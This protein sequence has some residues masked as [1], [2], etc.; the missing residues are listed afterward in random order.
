MACRDVEKGEEAAASIRA[1]CP[2]AEVE[3]RELDLADTCSIR[4]FAQKFLRGT[5]RVS[6]WYS[7]LPTEP[8]FVVIQQVSQLPCFFFLSFSLLQRSTNFISSSTTPGWWCAPTQKRLTALR[9]ILESITWVRLSWN[10]VESMN[11]SN[12]KEDWKPDG[13]TDRFIYLIRRFR[14]QFIG[15]IKQK[16]VNPIILF[17]LHAGTHCS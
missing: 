12:I 15:L 1:A 10:L 17:T 4:A 7:H 3:V 5:H 6:V 8:C 16:W 9:C 14:A 11:K 2:Q 13:L